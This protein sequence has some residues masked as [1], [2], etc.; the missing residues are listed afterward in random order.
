M[1]TAALRCAGAA[2]RVATGG[3][4]PRRWRAFPGSSIVPSALHTYCEFKG[5]ASYF[6]LDVKGQ[7]SENAAWYYP[8]PSPEFIAIRNCLAFYPSRVDACFVDGE[9]VQAQPGDYYGGWI[10]SEIKGP[11][12]GALETQ[13]W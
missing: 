9:K 12:K 4:S 5:Q 10:T 6:T 1:R 7:I 2:V 8:H 3:S 11:F 13:H